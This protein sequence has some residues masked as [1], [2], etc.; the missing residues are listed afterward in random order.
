MK[1]LILKSNIYDLFFNLAKSHPDKLALIC[2][3]FDENSKYA[4]L[5]NK[6]YK[7]LENEEKLLFYRADCIY[8]KNLEVAESL[9]INLVPST[10]IFCGEIKILEGFVSDFNFKNEINKLSNFCKNCQNFQILDD[11]LYYCEKFKRETFLFDNCKDMPKV[12]LF[13]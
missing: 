7:S 2:F 3:F 10:I 11:N 4:K 5:Q 12:F 6:I 8:E 1:S 13:K 9:G